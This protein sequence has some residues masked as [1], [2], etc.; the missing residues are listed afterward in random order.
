MKKVFVLAI[1]FA[2]VIGSGVQAKLPPQKNYAWY[3]SNSGPI[4]ARAAYTET[5][6]ETVFGFLGAG[7]TLTWDGQ[8]GSCSGDEACPW[9]GCDEKTKQ[10]AIVGSCGDDEA[11]HSTIE[12]LD[13]EDEENAGK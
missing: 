9:P 1:V 3:P 6:C 4:T 13:E 11:E 8:S 5:P 10:K 7:E 12:I 2:A